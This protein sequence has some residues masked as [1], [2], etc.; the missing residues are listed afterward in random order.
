MRHLINVM[1]IIIVIFFAS[2]CFATDDKIEVQHKDN[3]IIL[4]ASEG[5]LLPRNDATM[6]AVVG[7]TDEPVIIMF[8][9]NEVIKGKFEKICFEPGK[10]YIGWFYMPHDKVD[11]VHI[12]GVSVA[13]PKRSK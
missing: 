13:I 3:T 5:E 4:V 2:P 9:G 10:A 6:F 8:R 1:L 11:E 12:N 7:A